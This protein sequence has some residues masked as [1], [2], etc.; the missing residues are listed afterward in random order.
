MYLKN[1]DKR[2]IYI[3]ID[4]ERQRKQIDD[5]PQVENWDWNWRWVKT[6]WETLTLLLPTPP[7]IL[8]QK[9]RRQKAWGILNADAMI[10]YPPNTRDMLVVFSS[11]RCC[12]GWSFGRLEGFRYLYGTEPYSGNRR[13]WS[14]HSRQAWRANDWAA[15]NAFGPQNLS[16]VASPT[17][18][19]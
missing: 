10:C 2:C 3:Y 7:H 19:I 12:C 6:K 16:I 17:V 18:V 5:R 1:V 11:L 13:N 4:G 14:K 15:S 8:T 9:Q